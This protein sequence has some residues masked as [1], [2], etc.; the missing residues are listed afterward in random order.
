MAWKSTTATLLLMTAIGSLGWLSF[1]D[2]ARSEDPERIVDPE[3]AYLKYEQWKSV[4]LKAEP[5]LPPPDLC[6]RDLSRGPHARTHISVHV[7]PNSYE[8]YRDI[9]TKP[10]VFAVGTVIVKDRNPDKNETKSPDLDVMIKQP[11]GFSPGTGDWQYVHV[12]AN[13]EVIQGESLRRCATCHENAKHDHV[14][15]IPRKQE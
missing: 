8:Q 7:S 13:G 4:S 14:F 15:G 1:V 2:L 6:D 5:G 11:K 10:A 9:R 3:T 12:S